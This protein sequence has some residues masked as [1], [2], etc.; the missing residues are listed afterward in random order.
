MHLE[1]KML[2]YCFTKIGFDLQFR[3]NGL[4]ILV[5]P[6]KRL[7]S[8]ASNHTKDSSKTVIVSSRPFQQ[9]SHSQA[10]ERELTIPAT[11]VY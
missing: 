5:I 8:P 11:N 3:Y 6:R 7:R 4:F 10:T 2:L 1:N 9:P